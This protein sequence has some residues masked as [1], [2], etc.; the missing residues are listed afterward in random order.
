MN[1]ISN[2]QLRVP[3]LFSKQYW[4]IKSTNNYFKTINEFHN[5]NYSVFG[6]HYIPIEI[7]VSVVK[8]FLSCSEYREIVTHCK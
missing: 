2:I 5:Q 3:V 6:P 7:K 1:T 8:G 4:A